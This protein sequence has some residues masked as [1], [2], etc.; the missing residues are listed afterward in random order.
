MKL[1]INRELIIVLMTC[2]GWVLV[3]G[4]TGKTFAAMNVRI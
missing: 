3:T 1:L 4:F 2:K